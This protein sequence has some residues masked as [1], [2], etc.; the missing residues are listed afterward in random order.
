MSFNANFVRQ[1]RTAANTQ[2]RVKK[3]SSG[4]MAP[5]IEPM[6][7]MDGT[8]GI[9]IWPSDGVK[10][11]FG[12]LRYRSHTIVDEG[13]PPL[14]FCC[15]RCSNWDPI[16]SHYEDEE[17]RKYDPNDDIDP[18]IVVY[19]IF[20]ERCWADEVEAEFGRLGLELTDCSERLGKWLN[21][22]FGDIKINFPATITADLFSKETKKN[23]DTGA[24]YEERTYNANPG[25]QLHCILQ[26]K[27][28]MTVTTEMM[29]LVEEVPDCSD[30]T[31]GRWF[32]LV[33]QNDGK[34]VGGYTLT[35]SPKV[36]PAGFELPSNYPNFANWG[37]GNAQHKKPSS[38]ISYE[39]VEAV[40]ADPTK[41]WAKELMELGVVLSDD[42][43]AAPF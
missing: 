7:L 23:A 21:K 31:F 37:K 34:G 26:L 13:A 1:L 33:K 39:R 12:F 14:K 36:S 4:G 28:G 11:P 30:M 38:R 29:R 20:K 25:S 19:P 2:T 16:P 3:Y 10:N 40:G 9:R 41:W 8:Y 42:L 24:E 27:E 22:L 32:R 18:K 6:N 15:P 17:G 35:I 5:F 43:E